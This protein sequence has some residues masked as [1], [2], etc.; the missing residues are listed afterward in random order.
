M[1]NIYLIGNSENN[2]EYLKNIDNINLLPLNNLPVIYFP[3]DFNNK[4]NDTSINIF[5][6]VIDEKSNIIEKI[7]GANEYKCDKRGDNENIKCSNIKELYNSIATMEESWQPYNNN[8]IR[9]I[10]NIIIIFWFLLA[11]LIL[12]IL[13]YYLKEK[14]SIMMI[15]LI[16]IILSIGLIYGLF[17]TKGKI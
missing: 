15:I 12:K 13:H 5:A 6:T 10:S 1:E 3:F 9:T 4:T 16:S 7:S 14:Y 8:N 11:F 17:L 2:E